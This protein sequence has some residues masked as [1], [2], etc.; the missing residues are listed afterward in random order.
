MSE[1][2]EVCSICL[3]RF[4]LQIGI[5]C[6]H[7]FCM[8]CLKA[9]HTQLTTDCCCPLCQQKVPADF[10]QTISQDLTNFLPQ[11]TKVHRWVYRSATQPDQWWLYDDRSHSVIEAASA[12]KLSSV[13][14]DILNK[15]Y[16]VSLLQGVQYPKNDPSKQRPICR[17]LLDTNSCWQSG[18]LLGVAG[19]LHQPQ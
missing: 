5:P 12:A 4:N 18:E 10:F 9:Y 17:K 1:E 14:V 8:L 15:K 16:V 19:I 7:R 13:E 6:G 2:K 3:Q 11:N